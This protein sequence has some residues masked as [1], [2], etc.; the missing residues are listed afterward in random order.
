MIAQQVSMITLCR[1]VKK[2]VAK[3]SHEIR[4]VSGVQKKFRMIVALEIWASR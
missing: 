2:R 3:N 1:A 4:K